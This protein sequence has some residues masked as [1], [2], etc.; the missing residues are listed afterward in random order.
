MNLNEVIRRLIDSRPAIDQRISAGDWAQRAGV[1]YKQC[2]DGVGAI[3]DAWSFTL[4]DT[5]EKISLIT[6][7]GTGGGYVFSRQPALI[8]R[9]KRAMI[10]RALTT[11]SRTWK[12]IISPHL[13]RIRPQH[14]LLVDQVQ[15]SFDRL[16]VDTE[17]LLVMSTNPNGTP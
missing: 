2:V 14:P 9:G 7:F 5:G 8:E 10:K 6:I 11:I 12:G 16:I 3:R 13:E 4:R 1:S 17:R 15:T